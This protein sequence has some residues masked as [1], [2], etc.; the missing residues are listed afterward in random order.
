MKAALRYV[1]G[2]IRERGRLM[3]R[4][5]RGEGLG[6]FIAGAV[7]VYLAFTAFYGLAMGS[8]R[9]AH[10]AFFFSDFVIEPEEG[11]A[12]LTGTVNTMDPET[13]SV[14]TA[15]IEASRTLAGRTIR[16]NRTDPTPPYA[17][18]A[19]REVGPYCGLVL[20]GPPLAAENAWKFAPLAMVKVP[21]LFLV[22]LVVCLPALYVLNVAMG[23]RLGFAPTAAV[24]VF[25]LAA[26]AV[27]LGVLAPI[28]IFF[29]VLTDHY[30]FMMVLHVLIFIVAGAYGVQTLALGLKGL[31]RGVDD[32]TP[33]GLMGGLVRRG[34]LIIAW[35]ALY[36]FVGCQMAWS[37]R[38]FVGTPYLIEFETLR[39]VSTNF[40]ANLVGS[41]GVGSIG[42]LGET[43]R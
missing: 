19:A 39:P 7:A 1:D 23:W 36:M 11:L 13:S 25:A 28:V 17:I 32:T 6:R 4:V 43:R 9:W 14:T 42:K 21:A 8:F 3:E 15:D 10:P 16:F 38:P 2:F 37:L 20:E 31:R 34:K 5:R 22:T 40:Y 24:L 26:T 18:T 12:R 35:L 30:H 27:M 29:T 41:L 33:P